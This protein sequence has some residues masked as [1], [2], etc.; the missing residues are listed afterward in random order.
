MPKPKAHSNPWL[1]QQAWLAKLIF[2]ERTVK[3]NS[4][5]NT[6]HR[7]LYQV[8]GAPSYCRVCKQT[9]GNA[10]Y[11]VEVNNII[12]RWPS[13]Y[14]QYVEGHNLIPSKAFYEFVNGFWARL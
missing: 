10:E 5:T 8:A 11:T 2:I 7:L 9:N 14:R 13:G 12:Y 1:S 4:G 6:R 3:N